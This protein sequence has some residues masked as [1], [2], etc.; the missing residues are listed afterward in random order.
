MPVQRSPPRTPPKDSGAD[1]IEGDIEELCRT[2]DRSR[3]RHLSVGLLRGDQVLDR[4]KVQESS[5]S[6]LLKKSKLAGK[7]PSPIPEAE[8]EPSGPA[9]SPTGGPEMALTM[10]DFKEYMEKNTNL[11]LDNIDRTVS[12]LGADVRSNT[13]KISAQ[14]TLIRQNQGN[15]EDLRS[16]LQRVRTAP[17]PVSMP[18]PNPW[19]SFPQAEASLGPP[20]A[21]DEAYNKARRSL[22]L[23]P[24]PGTT[25]P[26]LWAAARSF[27]QEKLGASDVQGDMIQHVE[28]M[29][30]PS[31]PGITLEALVRFRDFTVRDRVIG[32]AAKLAGCQDSTGKSTAGMRIEVPPKL[33]QAFRVLFKYG[34][35]LRARHGPGTR[36]HVKFDDDARS[37][38]LNV[39][40]PN[41]ETWCRVSTTLALKGMRARQ[42]LHDGE[43]ER[44]LD[45]TGPLAPPRPRSALKI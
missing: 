39:R 3:K 25:T 33:Q 8:A 35:N 38:Y 21:D 7:G 34:Q 27:V 30:I 14:E 23:W 1:N 4:L 43:L 28:R 15:I 22:R 24:V 11:R 5:A 19:P 6:P 26:E 44:R 17:A 36:R 9:G 45:I 13:A 20:P 41:E 40:L 32:C 2:L 10:A 18:A 16:E 31:G 12:G 37:L 42:T 29:Q